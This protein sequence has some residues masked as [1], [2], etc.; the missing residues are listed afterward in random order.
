MADYGAS[1]FSSMGSYASQAATAVGEYASQ[2]GTYIANNP[3][4]VGAAAQLAGT[5]ISTQAAATQARA[6]GVAYNEQA[7]AIEEQSRFE[8]QAQERQHKRVIARNRAISG[9]AGVDP[10]SGSS[11]EAELSNWFDAG[12]NEGLNRYGGQVQARQS[13][14]MGTG[15]K[16]QIPSMY[17]AGAAGGISDWYYRTKK[18]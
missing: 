9:A 16:S 14:I 8:Q 12:M 6:Q 13:R 5:A 15:F 11:L 17:A 1:F 2:A 7:Q 10:F 4:T 3:A 18:P